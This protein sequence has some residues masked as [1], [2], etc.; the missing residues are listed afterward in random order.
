VQEQLESVLQEFG[1]FK[2]GPVYHLVGNHCLYNLSRAQLHPKLGLGQ[3]ALSHPL[4][5]H[6]REPRT[7]FDHHHH[8]HHHHHSSSLLVVVVVVLVLISRLLRR[9]PA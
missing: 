9:D 2:G 7:Q 6:Q 5:P 3:G 8:H 1:R 4:P